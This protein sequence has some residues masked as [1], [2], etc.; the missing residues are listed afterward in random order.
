MLK[1][2]PHTAGPYLENCWIIGS[3]KSKTAVI[4]DPGFDGDH[5]IQILNEEG[6]VPKAILATHAHPDH[7]TAAAVVQQIFAVPFYIHS[8]EQ[9]ILDSLAVTSQMLGIGSGQKPDNIQK[10]EGN[11]TLQIEDLTFKVIETPGH[12]P[13]SVAFLISSHLF[14]GDTLFKDS[15]GRTDLPGGNWE[16]L[17]TSLQKLLQLPAATTVYPGHGEITSIGQERASNPYLREL[18]G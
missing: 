14:C 8:D 1:I 4:I 6:W 15:I 7:I 11:D 12:T 3:Q 18:L 13:G 16:E 10:I 2:V 17:Q 9:P 5:V